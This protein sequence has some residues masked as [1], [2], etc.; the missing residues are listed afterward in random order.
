LKF[1]SGEAEA[2]LDDKNRLTV[3]RKFRRTMQPYPDVTVAAYLLPGNSLC[4]FQLVDE[5]GFEKLRAAFAMNSVPGGPGL[6][7]PRKL[8]GRIEQVEIDKAG[9]I[10]IEKSF[11]ER[12]RVASKTFVVTGNGPHLEFYGPD[13]WARLQNELLTP[14]FIDQAWSE[15]STAAWHGEPQL[16]AVTAGGGGGS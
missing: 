9:R 3:P 12:N 15:V 16:A 5:E 6:R 14:E 11:L 4:D 10:L 1:Y 7:D 8:I 2:S 13:K